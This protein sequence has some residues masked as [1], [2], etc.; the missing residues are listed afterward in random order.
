[1]SDGTNSKVFY[2]ANICDK[3]PVWVEGAEYAGAYTAIRPSSTP[4]SVEIYTPG[5]VPGPPDYD[6][7]FLT[8][9]EGF[10]ASSGVGYD[11]ANWV[12]GTGWYANGSDATHRTVDISKALVDTVTKVEVTFWVDVNTG[13]TSAETIQINGSTVA[14]GGNPPAGTNVLTFIGSTAATS[15]GAVIN[16]DETSLSA[17]AI[18]RMKVWTG[19]IGDANVRLSTDYGATFGAAV[20]VGTTP[21]AQGGFDLNYI[22][23]ASL[24]AADQQVK[25]ATTLGGA[26]SNEANGALVGGVPVLLLIAWYEFGSTTTNQFNSSSPQYLLGSSVE[27][28]SNA[29]WRVTGSGQTDVTPAASAVCIGPFSAMTWKGTKAAILMDIA[30]VRHLYS[31]TNL[32]GSPPTWTDRG[33]VNGALYCRGRRKSKDGRQLYIVGG[34]ILKYSGTQGQNLY[35]RTAPTT[36]PLRGIE[37]VG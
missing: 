8:S 6:Y 24:A 35:N 9:D 2:T 15:I 10:T 32:G 20:T 21:G 19:A 13:G 12:L 29:L 36:D 25:K 28:S 18:Q 16:S 3:P 34:S 23:A 33:A 14:S 4:G 26:Y 37:T 7:D 27:V 17:V 5:G 11:A 1:M 31:T 30:G 22:G